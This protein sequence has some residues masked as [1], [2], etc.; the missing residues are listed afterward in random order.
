VTTDKTEAGKSADCAH[1]AKGDQA[2]FK[3]CVRTEP[4]YVDL[5][6]AYA[7]T[8]PARGRV[9]IVDVG[10]VNAPAVRVRRGRL[11]FVLPHDAKRHVIAKEVFV[12]PTESK[13][14]LRVT[15][16]KVLIRRSMDP[17]C[18]PA[19]APGCGSPETTRDDQVSRGPVG[20]WNFYSDVAGVWGRWAPRVWRVRD[21]QL[22]RP[23][24]SFDVW[25]TPARPWR[26]FVWPRECDLGTLALAASG[27]LFP[28]PKQAEVGNRG[29]DDVPGAALASFRSVR[30]A[31]GTQAVDSSNEGSTCPPVN[32]NGCYRVTFTVRRLPG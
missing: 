22:I 1:R 11:T 31:L 8:L 23:R 19:A 3:A 25:L 7:Y 9:R 21:G 28:C 27:A 14:H 26:V 24:E 15:F 2:A 16:D 13:V 6:G 20:E 17:G 5:G 4:S 18:V 10:S 32:K 12:R 29:G 30:S